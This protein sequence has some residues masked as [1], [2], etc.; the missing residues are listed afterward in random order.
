MNVYGTPLATGAQ[1]PPRLGDAEAVRHGLRAQEA[2]RDGDG[3]DPV[4]PQLDREAAPAA[5]A[6]PATRAT[7]PVSVGVSV[8]MLPLRGRRRAW[9][10]GGVVWES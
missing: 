4:R 10:A 7:R 9:P 1:S 6:P 5:T 8:V 2:G 3:R